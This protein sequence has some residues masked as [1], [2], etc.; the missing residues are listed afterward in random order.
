MKIKNKIYTYLLFLFLVIYK[1]E[2]SK[3]NKKFVW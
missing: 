1:N 3:N 2:C